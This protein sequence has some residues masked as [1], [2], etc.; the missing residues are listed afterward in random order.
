MSR[1][2]SMTRSFHCRRK[3]TR[4]DFLIF[5]LLPS[6]QGGYFC[7][8]RAKIDSSSRREF[9]GSFDR[10][11]WSWTDTEK[12]R[13]KTRGQRGKKQKGQEGWNIVVVL[14]IFFPTG[15]GCLTRLRCIDVSFGANLGWFEGAKDKR[16]TLME[17]RTVAEKILL[18]PQRSEFTLNR[19]SAFY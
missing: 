17:T 18:H 9:L 15:L 8:D 11:D 13:A 19:G 6:D 7:V 16:G 4:V 2:S 5:P 10:H 3:R 1:I 14:V 12:G